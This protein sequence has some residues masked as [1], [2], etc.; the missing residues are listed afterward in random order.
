[1]AIEAG[2]VGYLRLK[3]AYA[4]AGDDEL[5]AAVVAEAV[6]GFLSG[7]LSRIAGPLALSLASSGVR[8]L[9]LAGDALRGRAAAA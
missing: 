5:G 6:A 9:T 3:E 8:Y 7:H 1:V 4:L 2:F